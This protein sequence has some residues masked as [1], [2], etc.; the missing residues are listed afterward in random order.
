MTKGNGKVV[1]T[2]LRYYYHHEKTIIKFHISGVSQ[3]K[4]V[5][6]I[7][8]KLCFTDFFQTTSRIEHD[9]S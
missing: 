1:L 4:T 3:T 7:E 6:T 5:I 9:D 2:L 8:L